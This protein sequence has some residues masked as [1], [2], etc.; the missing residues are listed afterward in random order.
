MAIILYI[1]FSGP[2]NHVTI[3]IYFSS[4]CPSVPFAGQMVP[5]FSGQHCFCFGIGQGP[6]V[7]N[8]EDIIEKEH[9]MRDSCDM[10]SKVITEAKILP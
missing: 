5:N 7:L 10:V 3:D 6:R 8:G 1:S 4:L 2:Q 9:D